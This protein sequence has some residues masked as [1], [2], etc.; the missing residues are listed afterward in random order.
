MVMI[1]FCAAL[2]ES[3]RKGYSAHTFKQDA[4]AG[5][6]VALVA[7][8]LAM[9]LAIAV[10][11]PPQ[12]GIYTAIIAGI[13]TPLLGGSIMQVSGPTAAFVVIIA[14][15]VAEHGLR[16]L[17]I[18]QIMAGVMLVLLA[19][20]KL[21]RFISFV[22]Y[23]V[24]TGFTAGIAVVLGTLALNDFFGLGADV[25]HGSFIDKLMTLAA[26][27]P[28]LRWQEA[29]VGGASL[30][31]MLKGKCITQ[32]IPATIL[33]MLVGVATALLLQVYAGAEVA[34]IGSRF[35]YIA[36]DGAL[37]HGIPPDLPTLH[38]FSGTTGM[39]ALPTHEEFSLLFLPALVIAALAA[40]ESLLS[41]AVADG[42]SRTRHEP[43][44]ELG[45]IGITNI[46]SALA[47]G[48]PATGAIARTT[49]NIKSGASTVLASSFHGVFIVLFVLSL[50][51]MISYLPM[52]SLAALLLV[53]AYNMSHYRQFIRIL[54]IA[55]R[56]DIIV[57]LTCFLLTV[58]I[59]MVAGVSMGILLSVLLVIQRIAATTEGSVEEMQTAKDN[60][61][62]PPGVL[63]YH[64]NG[65]LFFASVERVL[66]R[67]VF[68]RRNVH[69]L[70]LDM[71]HVPLID[72]TGL[73]A[74][75]TLLLSDSMHE[76]RILLCAHENVRRP[77]QQ[78]LTGSNSVVECVPSVDAALAL[79]K[80]EA[81]A[82]RR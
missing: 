28:M 5:L 68:L 26:N 82:T 60:L 62:L 3:L 2:K 57:L 43:N 49:T 45:A 67:T 37:V 22:P 41:A 70:I 47:T 81:S 44:A 53:V 66:D 6:L 56:Q 35:S 14:P 69:T 58:F 73:V 77:I 80:V 39:F 7:L 20:G 74:L 72:M 54:R 63:L 71:E 55:P 31:V 19:W 15:I 42:M 9:A 64:I 4:L 11:L 16:G 50:A 18:A 23:P 59:D 27:F 65:P 29:I 38:W 24:T 32:K 48:I 79:L 17:I 25:S 13:L 21:G 51:P 34:T 40:L 61:A 30:L 52:A 36:A 75:K 33:G 1:P 76:K 12:H 78:K 46:I 8:P 10:G